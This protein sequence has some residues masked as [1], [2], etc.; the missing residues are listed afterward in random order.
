MNEASSKSALAMRSGAPLAS[1][2]PTN[3]DEV[4]R[5]AKLAVMSGLV[6]VPQ[7]KKWGERDK[8][9]ANENDDHDRLIATA[10][11][12]ILHGLEVGLP[13]MQALQT[14]ALVN[15]RPL[16]WGDAVPALLWSRGFKLREWIEGTGDARVAHCEV[17]RPDGT[18]IERT[19]SVANAKAARLWDD[20]ASIRKKGKDGNY[21]DAPND[22]PWN[23]FQER[24]LQMRA[25][26]FAVKDGAS[27]VTRGLYLREEYLDNDIVDVTPAL[28]DGP[29]RPAAVD[30]RTSEPLPDLMDIP[31]AA[32][33]P[34]ASADSVSQEPED[35]GDPIADVEGFLSKLEEDRGFCDS[36]QELDELTESYA[37]V[38]K[39][40]PPAARKRAEKILAIDN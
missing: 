17:T 4:A 35:D 37:S 33:A 10:T 11:M 32:D 27:D 38:I 36:E 23:R 19:F 20:R 7:K 16:I 22:S 12:T 18:K 9:E 6:I 31:D 24:M 2:V 25:R 40:L 26:G 14:I 5:I 39:R 3:L 8:D 1:I 30:A 15:G 21:Y 34:D 29:A 13:P 28:T